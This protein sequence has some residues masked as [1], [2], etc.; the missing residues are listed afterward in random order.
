MPYH[1]LGEGKY[2]SLDRAYPLTGLAPLTAEELAGA[3]QVF[4]GH[5]LECTISN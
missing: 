1:R 3:R 2:R 5:G 4:A